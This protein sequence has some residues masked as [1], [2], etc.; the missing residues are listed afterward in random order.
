MK[1]FAV[2]IKFKQLWVRVATQR[3]ALG[4]PVG[5]CGSEISLPYLPKVVSVDPIV[6]EVSLSGSSP[7][8]SVKISVHDV[9]RELVDM[10]ATGFAEEAWVTVRM[11][12]DGVETDRV[13][14]F[15]TD[16]NW[17]DGVITFTVRSDED[18]EQT[19]KFKLFSFDSFQQVEVLSP[20]RVEVGVDIQVNNSTPWRIFKSSLRRTAIAAQKVTINAGKIIHPYYSYNSGVSLTYTTKHEYVLPNTNF[21]KLTLKDNEY[22]DFNVT[23][24]MIDADWV[25]GSPLG[26]KIL[27]EVTNPFLFANTTKGPSNYS[28]AIIGNSETGYQEVIAYAYLLRGEIWA[29]DDGTGDPGFVTMT[30]SHVN[31]FYLSGIPTPSDPDPLNKVSP[32]G[33]AAFLANY[34]IKYAHKPGEIC[35]PRDTGVDTIYVDAGNLL[36]KYENDP[37]LSTGLLWAGRTVTFT[38]KVGEG[39]GLASSVIGKT[40]KCFSRYYIADVIE[41]VYDDVNNTGN[42]PFVLK[43]EIHNRPLSPRHTYAISFSSNFPIYE[44]PSEISIDTKLILARFDYA[45]LSM[46]L[47]LNNIEGDTYDRLKTKLL[48]GNVPKQLDNRYRGSRVD[49]IKDFYNLLT[50][51]ASG[52]SDSSTYNASSIQQVNDAVVNN[53]TERFAICTRSQFV[54]INNEVFERLF[55]PARGG[56]LYLYGDQSFTVNGVPGGQP[57]FRRRGFIADPDV[58]LDD[59]V[60]SNYLVDAP[61]DSSSWANTMVVSPAAANLSDWSNN[62]FE[63]WEDKAKLFF[64]SQRYRIIHNAVPENSSDLGKMFP[65]VFGRVHRVP[66]IQAISRKVMLSDDLTAGDDVYVIASHRTDVRSPADIRL[67]WFPEGGSHD[68]GNEEL[69]DPSMK[70][71]MIISPFPVKL[72]GHYG[73]E[74]QDGVLQLKFIGDISTPY[75]R[76][77]PQRTLDGFLLSAIQLRGSEWDERAGR[78]DRRHP[79]RNGLG[80]TPLYATFSGYVDEQNGLVIHPADVIK[81]YIE[82]Y[83][84]AGI[85]DTLVD[86]AS[87]DTVK[88]QTPKYT[89]SVFMNEPIKTSEFIEKICSEFGF[90]Y[91]I[92]SGMVRLLVPDTRFVDYAKPLTEGLN[93]IEGMVDRSEGYKEITNQIKYEYRKNWVENSYDKTIILNANNNEECAKATLVKGQKKEKAIKADFVRSSNVAK[94]VTMRYSKLLSGKRRK[95]SCRARY[96][97]GIVFSPGDIVPVTYSDFG[98]DGAVAMV[99]KVTLGRQVMDLELF[100]L[101]GLHDYYS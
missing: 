18:I 41:D 62:G 7:V 61:S 42:I 35:A 68:L 90:M 11:F 16:D 82:L 57:I 72:S 40:A 78:S 2:D 91:F 9:K 20:T 6:Q 36:P 43:V 69:F 87:F 14:G 19:E 17:K 79:I 52:Q 37:D 32:S 93:L 65:I 5:S 24:E 56:E 60:G 96:V 75:H 22:I 97:E 30:G 50:T 10:L 99:T 92:S 26:N 95:L 47:P 27:K 67:E 94:E 49:S 46:D 89:S 83:G 48:A 25:D 44:L 77:I 100:I 31:N 73:I 45:M 13:V 58:Y 81:T 8:P 28:Y 54:I 21:I 66:L 86:E 53:A 76:L 101:G 71:E 3:M 74:E 98:F 51:V 85:G 29:L 63:V 12:T 39:E 80:S 23:T 33:E 15:L 55:F 84:T 88:S 34:R 64:A 70:R 1:H 38:N 4:D 59:T